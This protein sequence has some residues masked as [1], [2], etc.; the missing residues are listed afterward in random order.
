[1]TKVGAGSLQ[2]PN[3]RFRP[4]AAISVAAKVGA[5]T[6]EFYTIKLDRP[7]TAKQLFAVFTD[8]IFLGESGIEGWNV[9]YD[10]LATRLKECD[11]RVVAEIHD[12]F[13]LS[14]EDKRI[15][16]SVMGS[17][18][19]DAPSKLTIIHVAG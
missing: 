2:D 14:D 19:E 11:I 10:L 1:M 9:F 5:M 7:M 12:G 13:S 3:D 18:E 16:E 17:L 4:I 8:T 6:P 15:M